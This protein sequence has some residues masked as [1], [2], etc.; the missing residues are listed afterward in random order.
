MVLS[1]NKTQMVGNDSNATLALPPSY[2]TNDSDY[3]LNDLHKRKPFKFTNKDLASTP[4]LDADNNTIFSAAETLV[5][6]HH[7]EPLL[8]RGLQVPTRHHTLTSEYPFPPILL[9]A[10]VDKGTWLLFTAEV[11]KLAS[12][13]GP[14]WAITIGGSS[15]IAILGGLAINAFS[16]IPAAVW[17]HRLRCAMELE[18]FALAYSSGALA[19]CLGRWNRSYFRGKGI[20]VRV[21]IP[22]LSQDMEQMDLSTSKLYKSQHG[23]DK[24]RPNSV[25]E[26]RA[27]MRA[28]RRARIIIVPLDHRRRPI[29]SKPRRLYPG[30]DGAVDEE[31]YEAEAE[32]EVANSDVSVVRPLLPKRDPYPDEPKP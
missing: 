5:N 2:S 9:L 21:D 24:A 4:R 23:F 28:S 8:P 22:Y 13:S 12:L 15:A 17:G 10:G 3:S 16:F 14:Q 6:P 31:P 19:E 25:R 1:G 30:L 20:A 32:A 29:V 11:R 26:S 18:N 7:P 27:R